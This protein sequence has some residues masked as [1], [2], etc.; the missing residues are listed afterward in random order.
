M[1]TYFACGPDSFGNPFFKDEIG[2][3]CYVMQIDEHTADAGVIT[4]IE[5]FAD[6]AVRRTAA[7]AFD[8]DSH[9]R[10]A[11]HRARTA[12][13]CGSRAACHGARR[14]R[15]RAA[16]L[17]GST[18]EVLP[19]SPDPGL[20]LARRAIS[21]DVCL[22]ALMTTEDMLY[23]VQAPDFDPAREAFFQGK[24]EGPCR[25]GMYYMLQRRILDKIGLPRV[26]IVTLGNRSASTAG[27]DCRFLLTA[28]AGLVGHDMLFKMRL[29]TRPYE[30]R[31]ARATRF[32]SSY[33]EP[34]DRGCCPAYARRTALDA[35][36]APLRHAGRLHGA[37]EE[38]LRQA[39]DDF[40]RCA[41]RQA[42][43]AGRWSGWSA[44]STSDSTT[45]RTS[46]SSA[47]SSRPARR[48][49]WRP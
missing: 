36:P 46:T 24:S 2:E 40:A 29:R 47:S 49:G 34:A 14:A 22:P 42:A 18:P 17:T 27:W 3:P 9:R 6:T 31:R 20:N 13:A 15:R 26:D 5:A 7:P 38:L 10:H 45:A 16:R 23:R 48:S 33:S 35:R 12:G 39:Q 43:P 8:A 37:F 21:E 28:W 32:S 30:S 19:R 41:S 25:F 44:S 11:D 4:R 1:L